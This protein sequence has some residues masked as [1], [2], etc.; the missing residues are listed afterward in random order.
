MESWVP[1]RNLI[2]NISAQ[3]IWLSKAAGK[4]HSCENMTARKPRVAHDNEQG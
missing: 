4:A 1:A 3:S 2:S